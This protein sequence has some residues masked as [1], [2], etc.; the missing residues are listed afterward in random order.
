MKNFQ[1]TLYKIGLLKLSPKKVKEWT[2]SNQPNKLLFALQKGDYK[3]RILVLEGLNKLK[4]EQLEEILLSSLSDPIRPVSICAC[5]LLESIDASGMFKEEIACKKK[6]W[7]AQL[8]NEK[9]NLWK[10]NNLSF[11]TL[12]QKADSLEM[13]RAGNFE[14]MKSNMEPPK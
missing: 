6:Y 3:L 7:V 14:A 2:D 11:S 4:V 8:K 1:K 5:D 12:W 9:D 10:K 13:K